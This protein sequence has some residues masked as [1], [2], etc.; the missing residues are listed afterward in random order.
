MHDLDDIEHIS[1]VFSLERFMAQ[2]KS[3][4]IFKPSLAVYVQIIFHKRQLPY[5][6]VNLSIR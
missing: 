2:R 4:E 5:L 3:T 1:H 6:V